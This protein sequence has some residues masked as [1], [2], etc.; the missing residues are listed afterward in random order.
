MK[1]TCTVIQGACAQGTY[2]Q[3]LITDKESQSVFVNS[4]RR[5]VL[6]QSIDLL[7]TY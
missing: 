7:F 5:V 2:A 3:N 4:H 1:S 6:Q